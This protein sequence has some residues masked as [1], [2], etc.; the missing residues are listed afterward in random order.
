MGEEGIYSIEL[1]KFSK[2]MAWS[3]P[4]I[5]QLVDALTEAFFGP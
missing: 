1:V 4:N 2:L 5:V 3:N